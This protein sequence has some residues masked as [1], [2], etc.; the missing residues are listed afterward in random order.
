M[1]GN[2]THRHRQVLRIVSIARDLSLSPQGVLLDDLS[3]KY[4]AGRRT[5]E[6]DI[7]AL[8]RLG[9][10]IETT[11]DENTNQVRK[12][13]A[14]GHHDVPVHLAA[15]EIAAGHA[16]AAAL[17]EIAA[18]SIAAT[19][20]ILLDRWEQMQPKATRVDAALLAAGQA[21]VGRS[22]YAAS[23]D[24]EIVTVLQDAILRCARLRITYRKGGTEAP[25][26]YVAEPY[27][28]LHGGK[29][30]LIWRG[31]DGAFRKFALI[32]IDAIELTGDMFIIDP[33]FSTTAF[34][35]TSIGIM[36]DQVMDVCLHVAPAGRNRLRSFLFHQSQ[37]VEEQPDG[38]ALVRFEA[39]GVDEICDQVFAW[40]GLLTIIAPS[41]LAASYLS[42]LHTALSMA[43]AAKLAPRTTELDAN[44]CTLGDRGAACAESRH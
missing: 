15:S 7:D 14:N 10:T 40:G 21:L 25:R 1:Q 9:Y 42:R 29:N 31:E 41:E 22:R 2:A 6:R 4:G 36:I 3:E 27:G 43:T 30:Y 32:Y 39:A 13:V 38:S 12:R 26:Q 34:S 28:I 37:R 19:F 35:G 16:A 17:A 8:S 24:P 23:A 18:P 11:R 5:I 20:R 33:T 44:L